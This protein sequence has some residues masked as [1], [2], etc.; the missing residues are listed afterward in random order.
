MFKKVFGFYTSCL[1]AFFI[2]LIKTYQIIS[3]YM[4]RARCR[5][6]PTCSEYAKQALAKHNLI[7]SLILIGKRILKCAPWRAGGY[8][9]VPKNNRNSTK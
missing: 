8:D 1:K 2:A 7:K 4:F 9:P 3:K 5:F 6:H